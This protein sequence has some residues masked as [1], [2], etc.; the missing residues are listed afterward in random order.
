MKKGMAYLEY[1]KN[2]DWKNNTNF[3]KKDFVENKIK[4]LA[5]L[6]FFLKR[7]WNWETIR[8]TC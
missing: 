5:F 2:W 8:H 1:K 7:K 4:N 6:Q 3:E